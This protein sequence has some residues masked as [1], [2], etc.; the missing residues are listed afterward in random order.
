MTTPQET[1]SSYEAI[2]NREDLED[3]IWDVSPTETP[4]QSRIAK[5]KAKAVFHE[6]QTDALAAAATN[7]QVEGADAT[8]STA[9][10]TVRL[11]NYC[12][13]FQ[14]SPRVSGTQEAVDKAGRESEM[15]Y[16]VMKRMKELKRDLEFALV[17]NRASSAGS[18]T[19]GRTMAGLESWMATNKTTSGTAVTNA[20]VPGY[21]SG[22]V[23]APTDAS[24]TG[25]FTEANLKAIIQACYEAGG[26]P[27]MLM[28]NAGTKVKMSTAFTGLATRFR[29]VPSKQQAQIV[30]GADVYVSDFGVHTIVPNRFMRTSGGVN[31]GAITTYGT[32]HVIDPEYWALAQLR[33]LK[34]YDLS[35]VGD[36]FRK[37][38][39][40]ECTLVARNEKSSGQV[41]DINYAI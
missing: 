15:S 24:V 8:A 23:A 21:S 28:V 30:A 22:T 7:A 6:W 3:V 25:S 17:N 11:R 36:S 16:Q 20:S 41:R 26:D 34:Q 10:P 38:L 2:G 4:F 1:F 33:P 14:K 19:V 31:Q 39:V 5:I 12:Q 29:D 35:K 32:C 18:A 9:A 37:Q 13:I 27:T 40:M